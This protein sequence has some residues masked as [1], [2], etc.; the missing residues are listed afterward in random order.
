MK[1]GR[2]KEKNNRE[3]KGG[4]GEKAE[5]AWLV[6][7]GERPILEETAS[8]LR[9]KDAGRSP[10]SKGRRARGGTDGGREKKPGIKLRIQISRL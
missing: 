5:E 6:V 7:E 1:N 2:S 4:A 10:S 8:H 3:Q 9:T